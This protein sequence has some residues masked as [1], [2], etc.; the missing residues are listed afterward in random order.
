[1]WRVCERFGVLPPGIKRDWD[2]NVPFTHAMMLAYNQVR[3]YEEREKD[4][5][6]FESMIKVLYPKTVK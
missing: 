4:H 3:Q 1:M 2:S 5:D 6:F